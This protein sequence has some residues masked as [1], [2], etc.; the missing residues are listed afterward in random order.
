MDEQMIQQLAQ[1]YMQVAAQQGQQIQPDQAV[2]Q[3]QQLA[4]AAQQ[5]NKK[6]TQMLQQLVQVAQQ[7]AGQAQAARHGAKLSYV[8]SL[9][10]TCP[11]GYEMGYYKRGGTMCK[12]CMKKAVKAN[13]G[14][15]TPEINQKKKGVVDTFKENYKKRV[16][17]EISKMPKETEDFHKK[18]PNLSNL[19]DLETVYR[20]VKAGAKSIAGATKDTAKSL[21]KKKACGGNMRLN[22]RK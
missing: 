14:T 9:T 13:D 2:Q 6:A 11:E 10:N 17:E 7:S 4:Q 22:K 5:G 21:L 15:K 8:K 20:G 18:H 19:G 16:N 12:K 1:V 3:I